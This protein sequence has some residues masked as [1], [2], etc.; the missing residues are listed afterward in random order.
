MVTEGSGNTLLEVRLLGACEVWV[1]GKPLPPLR[2]RKDLWLLAQLTLRHERAVARGE[3]AALFWPDAEQSQALYYLRRS[4]SN[5]R[6]A[7]GAEARRLLTPSPRTLRLDLSDA[8]C[9]LLAFDAALARAGVS[10]TPEE[11]LQQ[12]ISLYRGP[13]LP[14][15]LEEWALPERNAREQAYLAALERLAR[16]SQEKGEPSVAVRWLRRLLAA[17]PYRESAY[18]TLMQAL[19]DCGDMAA[20]TQVYRDL[21]LLLHRDHNAEPA[22]ETDAL[23]RSL[24]AR[25]TRPVVF[26]PASSPPAGPPR[27]LPV[28]LSGLI[29]REQ[30]LEEVGGW[31]GKCRL[32]TLVG[33]GGVGKT[34]LAIAAA[35]RALG[36]FPEGVWFVDLAP[37]SDP[38]L[39]TQH[40]LRL[41]EIQEVPFR[42]PEETLEQALSSRTLLLVLDNCEHLLESIASLTHRL[43]S[44][45]PDLRI[46]A[47]SREALG[48]TGEHLYPV[49]SLSLPPVGQA[50]V[51]KAASSLLEYAAVQLF[52]ERAR[53]SSPAFRLTRDNAGLVMQICQ[54]LDGIP[55]AIEM[56]AARLKA[57]SVAQIAVRLEDRFQLLTGG[58]RA[59]LPRQHT[60]QATI[61]WSHDLLTEEER[62]LFRRLS[63]FAGSWS[64]EAA[65][66]VCGGM[67][68]TEGQILDVLTHLVE[69][70]LVVF[71]E[72][73]EGTA[74]YRLLESLRQY[75]AERLAEAGEKEALHDRHRDFFLQWAEEG[76]RHQ[77]STEQTRWLSAL[78]ED[79]D[80]L[81]AALTYCL[82]DP[83]GGEKGLRFGAS[84]VWFWNVHGHQSEGRERLKALLSH[85]GAQARNT[86]RADTLHGAGA[87]AWFQ[88]DYASARSLYDESLGIWREL[89]DRQGIAHTLGYLANVA[90]YQG[91]HASARSLY[92]ESLGIRREL[93][94][95][96]DVAYTLGCLAAEACRQGDQASQRALL[97]ESLAI[98]RE[99][100]DRYSIAHTLGNLGMAVQEEG[101]HALA[102][103]L[104]DESLAMHRELGHRAGIAGVLKNIGNAASSQGDYATARSL[105]DESLRIL[106]ELGDRYNIAYL[107][108]SF[109]S[110]ALN[111]ARVERA[112]QLW[113]AASALREAIGSPLSPDAHETQTSELASARK[114][115]GEAAFTTAW[116]KGRAMSLE[117][118]IASVLHKTEP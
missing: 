75:G 59:A 3:L 64:L 56:A 93:G 82:D 103:A 107:L 24:H 39:L 69:K 81:R 50:D 62:I 89:G 71:E 83:E 68:I 12:A 112:T 10:A 43:L 96:Y 76:R 2:Y 114:A 108:E 117:Q 57:L 1:H 52:V 34:R 109:A 94:D 73:V 72:P 67:G 16:I 18:N 110:L 99:L 78:E 104:Y 8:D 85:P 11:P 48:L 17:D 111:E 44:A 30:E 26:P 28:P 45:C 5:L 46:L 4:L 21:R 101:D 42:T 60:L 115:L 6:R 51:E 58:S 20:V 22:P 70:S 88:A 92:D 74:R 86:A 19:A 105:Y 54:R 87:M 106:R 100:G 40:L 7:L 61:D 49:P 91:D 98:F 36:Q 53:Q 95:R 37:L 63:V 38:T 14:D 55:L 31:L 25:E 23:Y 84:L 79:H 118:S 41:L 77:K 29:G 80:N 113:G 90:H 27:R 102:R 66:A 65:E 97:E 47:T 13:L 9:D 15:C 116:E 35:E 32:V 33:M